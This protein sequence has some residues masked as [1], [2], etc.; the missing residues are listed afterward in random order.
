MIARAIARRLSVIDPDNAEKYKANLAAFEERLSG[1]EKEW[2]TAAAPL[3]GIK[4]VTY[5]NSWPSF[6]RRFGLEV[7]DFVEPKPGI[8]P[9]PAHIHALIGRIRAEG[10]R[11]LL[12]ESYF[13]QKLPKKVAA[14]AGIP[15][16]I[17]PPSVGGEEG[18][19][20]YFGLFD[21]PL[22]LLKKAGGK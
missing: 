6:A 4:V 16:V 2:D 3:K 22:E 13:D 21:R 9:S 12:V 20:T 18:I 17:L 15:L 8:P 5:H 14:E 10:V 19:K 1:K 7:V 11:L